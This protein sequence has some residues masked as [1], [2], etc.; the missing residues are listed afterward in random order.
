MCK[1]LRRSTCCSKHGS[2][3]SWIYE[4]LPFYLPECSKQNDKKKNGQ[5]EKYISYQ[6]I[7]LFKEIKEGKNKTSK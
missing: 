1:R 5:N 3:N 4:V 6:I 2:S 7:L